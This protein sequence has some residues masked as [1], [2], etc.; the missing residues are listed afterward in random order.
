MFFFMRFD[1]HR[2]R[3]ASPALMLIAVLSLAAVLFVGNAN[4]GARRWITFGSMPPFQPSE[5]AKLAMIIYISAW[6]ASRGKDVKTFAL[7]FVPFI[8]MVGVVSGPDH[9]SSPTP[10]PPL[11]IVLTTM[12]LFFIAGAS[13]THLGA[14]VGIGTVTAAILVAAH[15]YRADRIV[16]FVSAEDDP[17]GIGFQI[18]QLLIALGSG[19]VHGLGL[20]VS[21]Q[22]FFYIP[23]AHTDGIFAIIGEEAGF[24]GAIVVVGLFAYLVFRGFRVALNRATTSAPTSPWASRS[25]LPSRR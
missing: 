1:Y 19:G 14:L 25:G 5:F 21:R 8:F 4:Y 12:A 16:A 22:K 3:L 9:A 2:L 23:G 6:L 17:S 13:M 7:G 24:V 10:A 11:I 18:L 20:G 15:S